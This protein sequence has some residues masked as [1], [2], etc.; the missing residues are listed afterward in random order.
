M[1]P[2]PR[3]RQLLPAAASIGNPVDMLASATPEQYRAATSLLLAD[4][5]VDS[6]L[7][8]FIPPLVTKPDDVAQAI[9][10]R[11][12]RYIEANCCDVHGRSRRTARADADSLIPVSRNSSHSA[13]AGNRIRC[14]APAAQ[15]LSYE[16]LPGIERDVVRGVID[17]R[18]DSRRWMAHSRR[19]ADTGRGCRLS[20]A[21]TRSGDDRR[22]GRL[23]CAPRRLTRSRSRRLG[24][25]FCTRPMSVASS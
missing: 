12:R 1:K 7:V 10:Q 8:I 22:R 25:R 9:A 19:G 11:L 5:Q 21:S 3:L 18:P 14:V 4:T 6:L 17:Q 13:R 16:S 15:G 2:S 24:R 20:I 23:R